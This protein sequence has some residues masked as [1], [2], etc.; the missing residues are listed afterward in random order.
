METHLFGTLN[1]AQFDVVSNVS[2][3]QP[4]FDDYQLVLFNNW[5]LESIAPYP[6]AEIER[7]VQQGGGLMIIGGE[8]NVYV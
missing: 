7:F 3:A 5:D 2:F 8:R 6:K 4:R 1:A